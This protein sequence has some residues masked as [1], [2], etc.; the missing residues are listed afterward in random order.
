MFYIRALPAL[1]D[2]PED[3]SWPM[4][5]WAYTDYDNCFYIVHASNKELK[6]KPNTTK[7]SNNAKKPLD[8]HRARQQ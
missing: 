7:V 4:N 5:R 2:E 1:F 6:Q 3:R 8:N